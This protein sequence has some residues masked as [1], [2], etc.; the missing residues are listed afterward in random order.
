MLFN[1]KVPVGSTDSPLKQ[2]ITLSDYLE[3]QSN[4][5]SFSFSV[6]ALSYQSPDMNTVLYKLE[7]YDSE[8]YSVGKNL[9]TYSNLPY[10]TYVLKV[11]AANSDGIWNP[12][13]RTLKIRILPPFY[14]SVWA[15][16]IYVILIL[17]ALFATFFYFRKRAVEKHQRGTCAV[18]SLS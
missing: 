10:G 16:I 3:L 14:L 18:P 2:S 4:Q 8:W 9:I 1:K 6:A 17:G 5:N 12:D 15:Y 13:V 7:G 11:K